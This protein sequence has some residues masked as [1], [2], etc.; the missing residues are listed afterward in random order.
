M[1]II[2]MLV[3][4]I[5]LV[6]RIK[7][8]LSPGV[9]VAGSLQSDPGCSGDPEPGNLRSWLQECPGNRR[10]RIGKGGNAAVV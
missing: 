6:I 5:I 3:T 1:R 7:V 9:T 4:A 8:Y 10:V 2:I